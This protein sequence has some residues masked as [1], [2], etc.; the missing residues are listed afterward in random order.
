MGPGTC[1]IASG[2][3]KI[4][5]KILLN[6][7]L[8][9]C[10][11]SANRIFFQFKPPGHMG[12]NATVLGPFWIIFFHH[13]GPLGAWRRP[14]R[15]LHAGSHAAPRFQKWH[16]RA[17]KMHRTPDIGPPKSKSHPFKAF[18]GGPWGHFWAFLA[19]QTSVSWNNWHF[20]HLDHHQTGF[21]RGSPLP[22][23]WNPDIAAP[24]EN[25]GIG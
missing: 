3:P 14:R 22:S 21:C 25:K 17:V 13:F 15:W 16:S 18:F 6:H 2:T 10:Q 19:P 11:F 24:P 20:D 4:G 7:S 5:G 1:T 8:T 23:S 9:L 12:L